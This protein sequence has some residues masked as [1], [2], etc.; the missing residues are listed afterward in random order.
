MAS[1]SDSEEAEIIQACNSTP[2]Y[3]DDVLN[4]DTPDFKGMVGRIYL[5]VLRINK[6]N[7]SDTEASFLGLHS[8]ISNKGRVSIR[9][10]SWYLNMPIIFWEQIATYRG[11]ASLKTSNQMEL[12][13][14]VYYVLKVGGVFIHQSY[15]L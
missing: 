6:A 9:G 10:F 1:L 4:I 15:R 14:C 12:W 7:V 8:T 13:F 11:H 5:I 3:L 2:G